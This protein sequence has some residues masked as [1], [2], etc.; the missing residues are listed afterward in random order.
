MLAQKP[1]CDCGEATTEVHH[2]VGVSEGG[3]FLDRGNLRAL[4]G[5]CHARI[6]GSIRP[7]VGVDAETGVPSGGWW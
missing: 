6:H 1:V 4:C 7:K 2:V 5:G 3:A